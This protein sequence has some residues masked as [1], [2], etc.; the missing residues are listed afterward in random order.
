MSK[1]KSNESHIYILFMS[2]EKWLFKNR[3]GWL[4]GMRRSRG[5]GDRDWGCC[6]YYKTFSSICPSW[7]DA[8]MR[9]I[10]Q[11]CHQGWYQVPPTYLPNLVIT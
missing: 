8:Q 2:L 9:R 10:P 6:F 5:G 4:W 7:I 11:E 1:M 3:K